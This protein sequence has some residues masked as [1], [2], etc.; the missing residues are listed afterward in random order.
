M[1]E[2]ANFVLQCLERSSPV[3]EIWLY[4]NVT[5]ETNASMGECL[6]DQFK[7]HNIKETLRKQYKMVITNNTNK[8]LHTM[9]VRVLRY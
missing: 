9:H 3:S 4:E 8:F 5:W 1:D 2:E 7:D 6:S